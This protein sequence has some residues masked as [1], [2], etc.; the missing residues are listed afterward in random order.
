M[1]AVC[2]SKF[3]LT[4]SVSRVLLS[5]GTRYKNIRVQSKSMSLVQVSNKFQKVNH[6]VQV[7]FDNGC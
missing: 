3:E 6:K 1:W 7:I 5:V 4:A 2:A